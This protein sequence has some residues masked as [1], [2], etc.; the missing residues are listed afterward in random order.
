[1]TASPA[2]NLM[3]ADLL[4]LPPAARRSFYGELAPKDWR[5]LV[6]ASRKQLGSPYA[7]FQDDPAGFIE[8]V[9]GDRMWSRQVQ[10]AEAVRDHNRVAV[11]AGHSPGKSWLAARLTAWFV[12]VYPLGTAK[13]LTTAPK[14]R[15]VEQIMWGGAGI[16]RAHTAGRL[17]GEVTAHTWKIGQETVAYGFSPADYDE[18]AVQGEHAPHLLLVVD[19]A[20]GIGHVLGRAYTSLMSQPHPRLLLLGNP[21]TDEEGSW[22]E[23]QAEKSQF[24]ETIRISAYDTPNFTGEPTGR[25]TTCPAAVPPHR[26]ASHLTT[27]EWVQETV[28]EFGEDAAYVIA[29]VHAQFP[30]GMGRKCIP[31]GWV[32]L[33]AERS[34]EPASGTW[35]RLGCD[36]ASDGGD[37]F[38]IARAI[39]FAV[40]IVHR[41]SGAANSDS[42]QVAGMITQ[43]VREAC[44]MRD[45]VGDDQLVHCKI[46]ASGLG[47]GVAGLVKRQVEEMN[48]PARVFGVKG[49]DKPHDESQFKNARSEIWWNGR[50]LMRPEV[51]ASTGQTVRGGKVKLVN[52]PTRLVAQLQAPN[53]SNKDTAGRIVVERKREMKA[54]G[55][56]SPDLADAVLLS[57]YESADSGPA[58][59]ERAQQTRIPLRPT[60]IA[61]S[62]QGATVIPLGPSQRR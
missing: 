58:T 56:Q 54:R 20:G 45:R 25:C 57:L 52:A 5:A 53:Y 36:I 62:G 23:E 12:C 2:A 14:M 31:Y 30:R 7:M 48:L 60:D 51:D 22:F 19:E 42:V 13:V 26:V 38:V 50:R 34:H 21:P 1:M 9:C 41:S 15:Q 11:P 24:V 17:P 47:W 61:A 6:T 10:V 3:V 43:H 40:E 55:V 35:V 27:Q 39:G 49:E 59:V 16:R 8:I 28:D 4:S 37:E 29:R 46:D 33:A 44:E 32:E 18:D